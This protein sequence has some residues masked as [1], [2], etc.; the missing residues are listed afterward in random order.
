M[1]GEDAINIV[2]VHIG[3]PDLEAVEY[4]EL[5]EGGAGGF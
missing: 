3:E 4:V 2:F 1:T 5:A